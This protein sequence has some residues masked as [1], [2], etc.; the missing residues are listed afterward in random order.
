[1]LECWLSSLSLDNECIV[2]A[3]YCQVPN[4]VKNLGVQQDVQVVQRVS[5]LVNKIKGRY[6]HWIWLLKYL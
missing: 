3:M 2:Y 5:H 6:L 4:I 1:M